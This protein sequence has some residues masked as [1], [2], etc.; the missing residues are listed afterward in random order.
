VIDDLERAG[1]VKR[2]RNRDDRRAYVITL[3][4]AGRKMQARAEEAVDADAVHFF[5]RLSEPELQELHRLL[6]RL[7]G[8]SE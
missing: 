6:A 5:G 8:R 4:A 7:S 3:T 2:G 1:Y